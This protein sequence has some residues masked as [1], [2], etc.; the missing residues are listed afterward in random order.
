MLDDAYSY[1][2]FPREVINPQRTFPQELTAPPLR[3]LVL[4]ST[5]Y[6]SCSLAKSELETEVVRRMGWK[7]LLAYITGSVDQEL[8]FGK[9][10][11]FTENRILPQQNPGRVRLRAVCV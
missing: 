10:Y 1:R 7:Q 5:C 2:R 6:T 3:L 4:I 11:L 8:L 9:E